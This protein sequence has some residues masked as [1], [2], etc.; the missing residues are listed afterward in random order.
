VG[1]YYERWPLS[2]TPDPKFLTDGARR[3]A[4]IGKSHW[5][6]RVASIPDGF[7]YKDILK[8]YIAGMRSYEQAGLG[9][10]L[11]GHLGSGKTSIGTIVLRNAL[12]RGGSI[13]S[14]RSRDMVDELTSRRPIEL[15]N[16]STLVNGLKKVNYLLIDD[17]L[18]EDKSWR[19][20]K[21]ESVLR[22]RNDER[23]PTIITTNMGQEDLFNIQWFKSLIFER[24]LGVKVTGIDWRKQPPTV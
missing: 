11:Y 21:I 7:A 24:Y 8:G 16:G 3:R 20:T 23:L 10:L 19:E 22:A 5:E 9:L 4:G 17:L 13:L 18:P 1:L 2:D 14:I 12:A 15:E 6:A